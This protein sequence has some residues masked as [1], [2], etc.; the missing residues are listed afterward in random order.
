MAFSRP[1]PGTG[2]CFM[3]ISLGLGE[4]SRPER[5]HGHNKELTLSCLWTPGEV[6]SRES[7][8]AAWLPGHLH[9]RQSWGGSHIAGHGSEDR[10]V[11]RAQPASQDHRS[12]F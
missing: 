12:T 11:K 9:W 7:G 10:E 8:L 2:F 5:D 3:E 1:R 4:V 6:T